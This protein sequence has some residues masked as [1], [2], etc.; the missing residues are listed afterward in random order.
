MSQ[1]GEKSDKGPLHETKGFNYRGI[2]CVSWIWDSCLTTHERHNGE[3]IG[4]LHGGE[5]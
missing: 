2:W 4:Y 3:K 1:R 5:Y